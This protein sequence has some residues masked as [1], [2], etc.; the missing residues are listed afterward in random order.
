[1]SGLAPLTT[2]LERPPETSRRFHRLPPPQSRE[3]NG[4]ESVAEA[5]EVSFPVGIELPTEFHRYLSRQLTQPSTSTIIAA[6]ATSAST[7]TSRRQTLKSTTQDQNIDQICQNLLSQLDRLLTRK[8]IPPPPPPTSKRNTLRSWPRFGPA[9]G[10]DHV[11]ANGHIPTEIFSPPVPRHCLRRGRTSTISPTTEQT[12]PASDVLDTSLTAT[13]TT[14]G[15]LRS[16][17]VSNSDG[18]W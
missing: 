10:G 6:R 3:R 18:D 5:W 13:T 14:T 17:A 16:A 7:T 15:F 12:C 11:T 1:M 8:K 2:T 4:Q 9:G